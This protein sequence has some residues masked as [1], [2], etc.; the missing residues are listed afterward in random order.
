MK[1]GETNAVKVSTENC[2]DVDDFIKAV[3]KELTPLLNAYAPAQISIS[4]REGGLALRRGMLINEI[5]EID[6]ND[7][8]NPLYIIVEDKVESP[9]DSPFSVK[10]KN[11]EGILSLREVPLN[12]DDS[13][14]LRFEKK[15]IKSVEF[16]EMVTI[17]RDL[18]STIEKQSI[19]LAPI[20]EDFVKRYY[21]INDRATTIRR[22]KDFKNKLIEFYF[23]RH[24]SR[25]NIK[26]M[27]SGYELPSKTVI[28][29]H[30]F[31]SCWASDCKARLGFENINDPRNGL[32]LFK[33][34]EFAFDNSHICFQFN[35]EFET[36]HLKILKP[37]LK[38]MSI[39]SYIQSEKEMDETILLRTREEWIAEIKK[40]PELELENELISVDNLINILEMPFSYFEGKTLLQTHGKCFGRCLSFQASM[41][42]LLAIE[43]N[44]LNDEVF[45]A[46]SMFSELEE[47]KAQAL[48]LWLQGL[49]RIPVK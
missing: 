25:F 10:I 12:A 18:K 35:R 34:F 40:S 48:N 17:I 13:T 24:P 33:P 31:K 2:D 27:L 30:L 43:N 45:E 39:K 4:S 21:Y 1:Y 47:K 42:R 16:N 15:G 37:E 44:W 5:P 11:S 20:I 7:D 9:W 32:L 8:E 49:E 36:F 26:C 22:S 19:S 29:A 41:A 3:M 23:R 28:G 6:K 46:P 38:D 14:Q